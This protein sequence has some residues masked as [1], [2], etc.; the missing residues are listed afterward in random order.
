MDRRGCLLCRPE[1][2]SHLSNK[3]MANILLIDDNDCFR[4]CT[5]RLLEQ[6]GHQVWEASNGAEA[7]RALGVQAPDLV[8]TDLFM[9]EKDGIETIREMKQRVPGVP[10]IDVSGASAGGFENN[11]SLSR[12]LGAVITLAKPFDGDLLLEA[13][14]AAE[15]A[16]RHGPGKPSERLAR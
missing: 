14:E 10:I 1:A 3:D 4:R 12:H 8:I 13:V 5:R 7:I 6:G 9:P 2:I 11:L 16:A 15:V